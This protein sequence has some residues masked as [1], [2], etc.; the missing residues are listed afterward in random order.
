M[1]SLSTEQNPPAA[2]TS[3]P[4]SLFDRL[5]R[6]VQSPFQKSHNTPNLSARPA[7]ANASLSRPERVDPTATSKSRSAST[8]CVS[9]EG[10]QDT[11]SISTLESQTPSPLTVVGGD[12]ENAP[13]SAITTPRAQASPMIPI[14]TIT[15]DLE[16]HNS[17]SGTGIEGNIGDEDRANSPFQA[18]DANSAVQATP[19][20]NLEPGREDTSSTNPP[21]QPSQSTREKLIQIRSASVW[22]KTLEIANQSLIDN[23]LP[24]LDLVQSAERNMQCVIK[25]L[26]DAQ[27]N[28]KAKQWRYSWRGR[29]IIVVERLGKILK[30]V[31]KYAVIVDTAIQHNPT[32]ASLVWAGARTILQVCATPDPL[33]RI[34]RNTL[35]LDR[36]P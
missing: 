14:P 13:P 5:V 6:R 18:R 8:I 30:G 22:E 2:V 33:I 25:D 1:G 10:A 16:S 23:K 31:Q 28:T 17:Q 34:H 26:E 27:A 12:P 32:V 20:S 4:P 15:V 3:A 36:S 24:P 7:T 19:L 35:R 11:A 9:L 29:E 21:A